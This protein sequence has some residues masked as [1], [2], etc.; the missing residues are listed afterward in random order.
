MGLI[1]KISTKARIAGLAGLVG[2]GLVLGVPDNAYSQYQNKPATRIG[3]GAESVIRRDYRERELDWQ[4]YVSQKGN[5]KKQ[6]FGD[7][8][9]NTGNGDRV[10]GIGVQEPQNA[11]ELGLS[12]NYNVEDFAKAYGIAKWKMCLTETERQKTAELFNRL[13]IKGRKI[14]CDIYAN[15]PGFYEASFS[16]PGKKSFGKLN[17]AYQKLV[18]GKKANPS[19][20][21]FSNEL[22]AAVRKLYPWIRFDNERP[23][24]IA[25]RALV[26]WVA[27]ALEKQSGKKLINWESVERYSAMPVK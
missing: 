18:A 17:Q 24:N 15:T 19:Q 8:I 16:E 1:N 25:D 20:E 22:E 4:D 26:L 14:L 21:L 10:L 7:R 5:S 27:D 13:D 9:S 23:M 6:D 2:A 3:E 11:Q 12:G